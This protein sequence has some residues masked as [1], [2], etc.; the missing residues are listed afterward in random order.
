MCGGGMRRMGSF[1]PSPDMRGC[2]G[3]TTRSSGRA[4]QAWSNGDGGTFGS[5][6]SGRSAVAVRRGE[7]AEFEAM[8]R[9]MTSPLATRIFSIRGVIECV[10]AGL[11]R[12]SRHRRDLRRKKNLAGRA[13]MRRLRPAWKNEHQRNAEAF[14]AEDLPDTEEAAPF[15]YEWMKHRRL[16]DGGI[17]RNCG[18]I[19]G[20][21][22]PRC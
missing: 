3:I 17:S 6:V 20:R 18:E 14:C 10:V 22:M 16:M 21:C 8:C 12:G 11:R 1:W 4:K 19:L 7:T 2:D 5:V 9:L 13:P 15:Y